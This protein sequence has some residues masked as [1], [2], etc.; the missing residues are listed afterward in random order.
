MRNFLLVTGEYNTSATD[1]SEVPAGDIGIFTVDKNSGKL[2]SIKGLTTNEAVIVVGRAAENGGPIVVPFYNKDL[3]YN[4]SGY[5]APTKFKATFTMPTSNYFDTYTIIAVKK[6]KL[7]NERCKF[8]IDAYFP[9][10]TNYND[11]VNAL[12]KQFETKEE[13]LGL[14]ASFS[15]GTFTIEAVNAGEDYEIILADKL[16]DKTVTVVTS[17]SQ[18]FGTYEHI[19]DLANKAAADSG[20]NY[21]YEEGVT[22]YPNYPL[23]ADTTNS[24]ATEQFCIFNIRFAEPRKVRTVDTVAHQIIQIAYP[25][26][27][28]LAEDLLNALLK[29][30]GVE[31]A[32]TAKGEEEG[33]EGDGEEENSI[34]PADLVE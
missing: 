17:G 3:T 30:T 5:T 2:T 21:T 31:P 24:L 22:M 28:S 23:P 18:G 6:G 19:V 9:V 7:F 8:T 25:Y 27:S 13:A 29:M 1:Y 34:N 16:S 33:G 15:A 12:I 4:F 14:K 26:S 11:I 10:E 20:F 32:D